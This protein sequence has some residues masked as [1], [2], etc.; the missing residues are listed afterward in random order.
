[1]LGDLV[2][3][4]KYPNGKS[5]KRKK[6]QDILSLLKFIPP[7]HHGF[8]QNLRCEAGAEENESDIECIF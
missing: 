7:V 1:L 5:I 8:Y 4:A 6:L 3:P 2:F